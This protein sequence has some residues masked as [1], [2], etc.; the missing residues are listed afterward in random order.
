MLHTSKFN[1]KYFRK[2]KKESLDNIKTAI[3]PGDK[4]SCYWDKSL[5]SQR[6][7][8][9]LTKQMHTWHK[10]WMRKKLKDQKSVC[11]LLIFQKKCIWQRPE[12]TGRNLPDARSLKK[13]E[14]LAVIVRKWKDP[15]PVSTTCWPPGFL[16][17]GQLQ[18]DSASSPEEPDRAVQ[19]T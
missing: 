13:E 19:L 9:N 11:P 8:N 16:S 14:H 15:C 3:F 2:F 5:L 7:I 10:N 18:P 12:T 6:N 1:Q 4:S 17:P